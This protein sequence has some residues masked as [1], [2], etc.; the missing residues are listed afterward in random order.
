[1]V[2]ELV[3]RKLRGGKESQGEYG[4]HPSRLPYPA[5]MRLWLP[6]L[7]TYGGIAFLGCFHLPASYAASS[8]A[9]NLHKLWPYSKVMPEALHCIVC[10]Y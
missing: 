4:E 7:R 6:Y 3:S 2:I 9:W 10:L 1:M 5:G 8:S